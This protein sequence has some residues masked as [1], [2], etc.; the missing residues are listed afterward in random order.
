MSMR[1]LWRVGLM[2]FVVL[3]LLQILTPASGSYRYVA[4]HTGRLMLWWNDI[5]VTAHAQSRPDC[6]CTESKPIQWCPDKNFGPCTAYD[7]K[8]TGNSRKL[9]QADF[10]Q[11]SPPCVGCSQ[12][13]NVGCQPPPRCTP[14]A[15]L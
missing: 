8:Y 6:D 5:V 9:C 2:T 14:S 3:G 10:P 4:P 15:C 13:H 11:D 7:C 1:K 12:S